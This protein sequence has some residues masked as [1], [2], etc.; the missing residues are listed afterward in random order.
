MIRSARRLFHSGVLHQAAMDLHSLVGHLEAVVPSARAESWDNVGLLVEPSGNPSISH[1]LLTIDLTEQV[2]EEAQGVGA[3]L[4][5]A[6]HPPIFQ[7]LKKL[8]QKSVKER[9]VVRALENGVA[10]YS[11]HT[12]LDCKEGGVNDWL[13]AGLGQGK[14]QTLSVSSV[15]PCPSRV[16]SLSGVDKVT[17]DGVTSALPGLPFTCSSP[18]SRF[19][20][21]THFMLHCQLP[22][23]RRDPQLYDMQLLCTDAE[24]SSFLMHLNTV[25]PTPNISLQTRPLVSEAAEQ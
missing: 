2:L 1:V 24:I 12:A 3:R 19:T 14:V 17:V 18:Y 11:P 7:P 25:T 23:D 20:T 21:H 4:V 16:L 15:T 10:V 22:P 9:I 13:L 8:T 5:V 6:Y